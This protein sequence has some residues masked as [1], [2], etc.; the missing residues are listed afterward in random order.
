MPDGGHIIDA[1]RALL[2]GRRMR[3]ELFADTKLTDAAWSMLVEL[4][5]ASHEGRDT[6]INALTDAVRVPATTVLRWIDTFMQ[7]DYVA[8]A[9]DA[10][11]RRRVLVSLTP[12]GSD[13][14]GNCI[15]EGVALL[16]QALSPGPDDAGPSG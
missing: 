3:D 7:R 14:V 5:V 15:R 12:K 6:S 4:Y 11:D 10:T 8:R 1:A 13:M 9:P 16:M 2:L